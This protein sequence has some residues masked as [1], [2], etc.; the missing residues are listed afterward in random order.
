MTENI[1]RF[2]YVELR[3]QAITAAEQ[4]VRQLVMGVQ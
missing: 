4:F 3:E 2:E 1:L